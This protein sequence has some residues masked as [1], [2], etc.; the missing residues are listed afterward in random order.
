MRQPRI[1]SAGR[2][3]FPFLA[4]F[5][6]G[7]ALLSVPTIAHAQSP[8]KPKFV[9]LRIGFD[10]QI[11]EGQWA[12]VEITIRGGSQPWTGFVDIVTN[13]GDGVPS[14]VR[15]QVLQLLPGRDTSVLLYVKFAG[16]SQN[17]LGVSFLTEGERVVIERTFRTFDDAGDNLVVPMPLGSEQKL[18]V[19]VGSSI[20]LEEVAFEKQNTEEEKFTVARLENT[21]Q[22]PTRWFG[23]EGVDLLVMTTS[24]SD[25]YK[26]FSPTGAQHA[27]LDTWIRLGGRL[28]LCVGGNALAQIIGRETPC[29]RVRS[30]VSSQS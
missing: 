2:T 11:K 24:R 27:A 25:I 28:L 9:G 17:E 6:L 20:G 7:I 22:L 13:D 19:A 1:R 29:G 26:E 15:S 30:R 18:I 23:Y 12:P 14:R 5:L 4:L 21:R 8:Q 10:N 3:P 16:A